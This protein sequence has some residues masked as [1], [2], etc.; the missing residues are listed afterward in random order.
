MEILNKTQAPFGQEVWATIESE[1]IPFK[2]IN[3]I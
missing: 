2:I 3:I 1:L